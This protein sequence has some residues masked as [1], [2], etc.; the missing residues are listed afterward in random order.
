M[1]NEPDPS[2]KVYPL[3][4]GGAILRENIAN[5]L[6]YDS[7]GRVIQSISNST[8]SEGGEAISELAVDPAGKSVVLYNPK[9]VSGGNTGSRAKLVANNSNPTDIYYSVDRALRTVIVSNNGELIAMASMKDGTDD[10]V[11]ILDRFGNNL[12]E[13]EFD[14]NIKGVSFSENG[15][16]ITI[17]SGGR[18]AA[19]EIRSK[20]RVG[21]TSFR[22]TSLLYANY[23]PEDKTIVAVTGSGVNTYSELE[24]H[25]VNVAARKIAR[26]DI[27]GT[28]SNVHQPLLKRNG[29]GRYELTGFS[30]VLSIRASF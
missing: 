8:Q 30:Q 18:A 28:I 4:N 16:F 21:S 14:Q 3:S 17:Y 27:N 9:I 5:F 19:Y 7:F 15:L 20:E 13:I 26:V 12:G 6:F 2:I 1:P 10:Q 25:A 29:A 23:S 24:G 11:M 22:N